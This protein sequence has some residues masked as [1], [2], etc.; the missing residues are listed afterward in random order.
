MK[1]VLAVLVAAVALSVSSANAEEMSR[2]TLAK[3]G[4]SNIK[5]MSDAE[6]MQVRG[7]LAIAWTGGV[8]TAPGQAQA[9]GAFAQGFFVANASNSNL[10]AGANAGGTTGLFGI[11]TSGYFNVGIG[12]TAGRASASAF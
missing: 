6:G 12:V 8:A 11:P 10:A 7:K 5:V 4:F 2:S 1:T 3:M 9:S